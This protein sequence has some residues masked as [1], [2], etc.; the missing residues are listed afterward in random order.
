MNNHIYH[1]MDSV[2]TNPPEEPPYYEVTVKFLVDASSAE[3]AEEL[4]HDKLISG[5]FVSDIFDW[6][7][8]ET[9]SSE[10]L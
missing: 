8:H 4:V 6:N 2:L 7:I 3:N 5:R 10:E 9:I 1:G